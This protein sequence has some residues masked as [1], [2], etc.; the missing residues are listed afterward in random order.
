MLTRSCPASMQGRKQEAV[1]HKFFCKH[2][3]NNA[4]GHALLMLL[5]ILTLQ[6][7]LFFVMRVSLLIANCLQIENL[8]FNVGS[9]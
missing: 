9:V 4:L 1:H 7:P 2:M 8:C 3:L 5:L 6:A